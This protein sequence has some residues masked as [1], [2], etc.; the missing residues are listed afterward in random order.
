MAGSPYQGLAQGQRAVAYTHVPSFRFATPPRAARSGAPPGQPAADSLDSEGWGGQH[1]WLAQTVLQADERG[2]ADPGEAPSA[3]EATPDAAHRDATSSSDGQRPVSSAVG[4]P[5]SMP[6]HGEPPEAFDHCLASSMSLT[7]LMEDPCASEEGHAPPVAIVHPN[8]LAGLAQAYDESIEVVQRPLP[9]VSGFR[10]TGVMDAAQAAWIGGTRM[11]R[12]GE[13]L[14]GGLARAF[15]VL[16]DSEGGGASDASDGA[17]TGSGAAASAADRLENLASGQLVLELGMGRGRA[18]L[19][20]FLSGATVIGVELA[21]ERYGLAVAALERLAHRCPEQ[22]EI[23]RRT[24]Q[25]VRIRRV[26][27]PKAAICE[28]RLGNFF[29]A[30]TGEEVEAATMVLLQVCLPQ[31]AWPR[32]RS[33]LLH[34]QAGCRILMY[35]DL[36]KMWEGLNFPFESLGGPRLACSWAPERGH[37]FHCYQR[38]VASQAQPPKAP[39]SLGQAAG[40]AGQGAA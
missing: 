9:G 29:D 12:Y 26:G 16:L 22:F 14:P 23:S 32:L 13:L 1:E 17:A 7:S 3:C 20:L 24:S 5:A 8:V 25:A 28:V 15:D 38:V 21:N 11:L 35:E 4:R 31:P 19:Q 34:T 40:D 27:G 30:V 36:R 2:G 37:R 18:A 10:W 33:L 6:P 39:V